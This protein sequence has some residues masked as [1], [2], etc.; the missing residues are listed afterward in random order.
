MCFD[1][2]EMRENLAVERRCFVIFAPMALG[3]SHLIAND[4]LQ[5][6]CRSVL[7]I[8]YTFISIQNKWEKYPDDENPEWFHTCLLHLC[9]K[10]V[11]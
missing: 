2:F 8:F 9:L 10:T 1:V 11:C 6:S 5:M 7:Y 3:S 4:L